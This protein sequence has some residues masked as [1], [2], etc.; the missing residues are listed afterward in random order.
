MPI[1]L[2]INDAVIAVEALKRLPKIHNLDVKWKLAR[3]K[4]ALLD[5]L[6]P[7]RQQELD[8]IEENGGTVGDDGRTFTW[9]DN[10]D[11]RPYNKAREALFATEITVNR[12]PLTF[13]VVRGSDPEREPDFDVELLSQ[14]RKIIVDDDGAS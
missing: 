8:L 12:N 13:S 4:D 11:Q 9:P 5:E 14:L 10:H 7:L 2:T 3:I 1:T 6:S